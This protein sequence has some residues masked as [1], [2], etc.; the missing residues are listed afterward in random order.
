MGL[1]VRLE[2]DPNAAVI[3]PIIFPRIP[4]AIFRPERIIIA[5][6]LDMGCGG[7]RQLVF[8][9]PAITFVIANH[10]R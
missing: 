3:I 8:G 6:D 2:A 4:P 1:H 7:I 10:G 5:V 9:A